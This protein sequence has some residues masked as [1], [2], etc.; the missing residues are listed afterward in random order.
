MDAYIRHQR[1]W[2][3]LHPVLQIWLSR[4]F[5][6]K[7]EDLQVEGP[8]I[9][10]PNHVSAWDPF[11]VA[12]SLRE[13]QVYFVASEHLFRL[14]LVSKLLNWLVAPIPRRKGTTGTDTVKACLRHLRQ[15]HSV[16]LF[17]EGE[18][19]WDGVSAPI[20]P[21][22]G[23]MVKASGATL[24]TYRLEGGYLSCPRWGRGVRRGAVYGHPVGVYPP[25]QLKDMSAQEVNALIQRDIEEDA[26]LRQQEKAVH[27]R[28]RNRAEG[29][30]RALYACPACLRIGTLRTAGDRIFCACGFERQY[31]ETG[32]F[33]P[34]EPFA[35]ID[36]WDQWQKALVKERG[37]SHAGELL[38]WDD[39][40]ELSRIQADHSEQ[41]LLTGKL[42]QYENRLV[43]GDFVFPLEEIQT[44]AEVQTHLLLVHIQ[45]E[46][47]QLRTRTGANLKKYLDIWKEK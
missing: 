46:Y 29:M 23:K 33:S 10:I 34:A 7:H 6:L 21:A 14:G 40:I 9:L 12:M 38:F 20:F 24:V 44:M 22:T 47:Y 45:G 8:V 37:F 35:R 28:G 1:I 3:V 15:G 2:R 4:K 25:E 18:Q 26:W 43:C 17:A 27:F 39:G 13:K 30:E 11:L 19:C 42:E 5:N 16:C 31:L 41:S 32:F 36:Q